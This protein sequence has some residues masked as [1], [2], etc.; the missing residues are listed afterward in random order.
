MR[1]G[2]TWAEKGATDGEA[3]FPRL[4]EYMGYILDRNIPYTQFL[5]LIYL[6]F[7]APASLRCL[8]PFLCGQAQ[9]LPHWYGQCPPFPRLGLGTHRQ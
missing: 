7:V 8:D 6:P 4:Q 3:D 5:V 1:I 2:E 9:P